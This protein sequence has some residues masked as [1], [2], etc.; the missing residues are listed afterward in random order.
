[1]TR[2]IFT[3][4]ASHIFNK[5]VTVGARCLPHAHFQDLPSHCDSHR[6]LL[7]S[8]ECSEF[9]HG[10][11]LSSVVGLFNVYCFTYFIRLCS[12][13]PYTVIQFNFSKFGHVDVILCCVRVFPLICLCGCQSFIFSALS[14]P[15][16]H[17][18]SLC[19]W[20]VSR[21]SGW[22]SVLRWN[23]LFRLDLWH[24]ASIFVMI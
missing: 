23:A 2:D 18:H 12:W 7:E 13:I 6:L 3:G 21:L 20:W 22:Y 10:H 11:T 15:V 1:M 19:C 8:V 4:P 17:R 24:P 16:F 14:L 5:H 9:M